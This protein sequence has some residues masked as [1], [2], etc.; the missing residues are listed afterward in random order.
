MIDLNERKNAD[1]IKLYGN[2]HAHLVSD[3]S[4]RNRQVHEIASEAF[5]F[6]LV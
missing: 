2:K 3:F 4:A 5:D 1:F 6:W